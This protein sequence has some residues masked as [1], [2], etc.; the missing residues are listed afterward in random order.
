MPFVPVCVSGETEQAFAKTNKQA[1]LQ[2]KLF[3]N[4]PMYSELKS[5]KNYLLSFLDIAPDY[6][7]RC[8]I[9]KRAI[10]QSTDNTIAGYTD[11]TSFPFIAHNVA[12]MQHSP[13]LLGLCLSK[14][15]YCYCRQPSDIEANII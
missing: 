4:F 10:K 7:V 11:G 3:Y 15:N 8:V 5:S 1:L 6:L 13:H 14:V 2:P 12:A 9:Q